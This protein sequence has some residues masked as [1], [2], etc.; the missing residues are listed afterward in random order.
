MEINIK[1]K[2]K[3]KVST[4]FIDWEEVYVSFLPRIFHF[5]C[6]RVGVPD[7]AEELTSATF[8]KA[9]SNRINYRQ[10]RGDIKAWIFGIARKVAAD[11]FRQPRNE[12]ALDNI[13]DIADPINIEEEVQKQMEFRRLILICSHLSDREKE[14]IALKYGAELTNREISRMLGM[15]ESNVGTIL[16]RVVGKIRLEMEDQHER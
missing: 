8:E 16:Y 4:E 7:K 5:F 10:E 15:S 13:L 1:S 6:F 12:V 14:L 3:T 9:W 2:L 11:Y